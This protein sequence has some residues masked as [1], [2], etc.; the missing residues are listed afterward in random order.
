[1]RMPPAVCLKPAMRKGGKLS[2]PTRIAKNVVPQKNETAANASHAKSFG[3]FVA[4][5]IK[6]KPRTKFGA[7]NSTRSR[8][9]TG[10]RVELTG[11]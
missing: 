10:T 11:V 7:F 2:T 4:L 5:F 9:R 8:G 3:L 6:A 1:M